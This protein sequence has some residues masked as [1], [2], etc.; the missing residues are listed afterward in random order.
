MRWLSGRALLLLAIVGGG[1]D[2]RQM[3]NAMGTSASAFTPLLEKADSLHE[4]TTVLLAGD[5]SALAY[6]AQGRVFVSK[7]TGARR[8]SAPVPVSL[9]AGTQCMNAMWAPLGAR[10]AIVCQTSGS[11]TPSLYLWAQGEGTLATI[12]EGVPLRWPV[13]WLPGGKALLYIATE[14]EDSRAISVSSYAIEE[15]SELSHEAH[16]DCPA[17]DH[18]VGWRH[19]D[20]LSIQCAAD[21]D[22][23]RNRNVWNPRAPAVTAVSTPQA[24]FTQDD[25]PPVSRTPSERTMRIVRYDVRGSTSI[26]V[27]LIRDEAIHDN[28]GNLQRTAEI[29]FSADGR[30]V[31]VERIGRDSTSLRPPQY[32]TV[33]SYW[34]TPA[35][36]RLTESFVQMRS[37]YAIRID[38]EPPARV[39][40]LD[41]SQEPSEEN[42]IGGDPRIRLVRDEME[43]SSYLA[44]RWAIAADGQ[45]LAWKTPKATIWG[46]NEYYK[47]D[48]SA[49]TQ[50]VI[51]IA[52][53]STG[54]SAS[55]VLD[56]RDPGKDDTFSLA[57]MWNDPDE[58]SKIPE[59]MNWTPDGKKLLVVSLGALWIIDSATNNAHRVPTAQGRIVTDILWH[60][61]SNA[62]VSTVDVP[63]GRPGAWWVDLASGVAKR[64]VEWNFSFARSLSPR[65][66]HARS[67]LVASREVSG[68][69]VVSFVGSTAR[70]PFNV[71][72]EVLRRGGGTPVAHPYRVTDAAVARPLPAVEDRTFRFQ[73][74]SMR[75]GYGVLI[76]PAGAVGPLPTI[77]VA[78]PGM[79]TVMRFRFALGA[80][81]FM[82]AD[83][84]ATLGRGYAILLLDIPMEGKGKY[85]DRGPAADIVD[86]MTSGLDAAAL[87]GWI[88]PTRLG[89]ISHSYGGYMVN[90]LVAR[91][92]RFAAAVAMSGFSDFARIA[93]PS[94]FK[95]YFLLGQGR[96]EKALSD[97]PERYVLNSP[98]FD[99]QNVT[100]P[101]L[102]IHGTRDA[103]V[104]IQQSE[105]MFEALAEAFKPVAI[106]RYHGERHI[107]KESWKWWERAL[108]WFDEYLQPKS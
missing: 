14:P 64:A 85:G 90:L 31:F 36:E 46:P 39:A 103:S 73:T 53:Q 88:D 51:H 12:S 108:D 27:A 18:L 57:R 100:T 44:T 68:H 9:P 20:R 8:G 69:T 72:V 30:V 62:F 48:P 3:A 52:R 25:V 16:A 63:T 19:R 95:D 92:N 34:R 41:L 5:G 21:V 91:T 86:G 84:F 10:L 28:M 23:V 60:T 29:G 42:L 79:Q 101:L 96:M 13:Q 6:I 43:G 99:L 59:A 49:D 66:M 83:L 33:G 24:E 37:L 81:N 22:S 47:T 2:T 1:V 106:V 78:Y 50:D 80:A 11:S 56:A 17:V 54:Q 89:V 82:G 55:V 26:S 105:E 15:N 94:K 67:Q 104:S 35:A 40:V 70:T 61:N 97:A 38:E 45:S 76:R 7:V 74:S 77:V 93:A 65:L 71:Y 75:R 107:P 58:I 98:V 102:L 32:L 87:S 4:R